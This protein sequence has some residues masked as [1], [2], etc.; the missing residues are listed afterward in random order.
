MKLLLKMV[1][2]KCSS[3]FFNFLK[4]YIWLDNFKI[5]KII[6]K[7]LLEEK[8][9]LTGLNICEYIYMTLDHSKL[10]QEK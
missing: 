10:L 1:K 9:L 5:K 3:Y 8:Y 4:Q 6:Y 7:L 2:T